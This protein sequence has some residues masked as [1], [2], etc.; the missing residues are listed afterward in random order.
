MEDKIKEKID[1]I[2]AERSAAFKARET[3]IQRENNF[4]GN[5]F[6]KIQDII[7]PAMHEL[8]EYLRS[9]NYYGNYDSD[10]SEIPSASFAVLPKGKRGDHP[11]N[12]LPRIMFSCDPPNE[13]VTIT[14]LGFRGKAKEGETKSISLE[15]LNKSVVQ[16]EI[17]A[18]ISEVFSDLDY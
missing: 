14:K 2:V 10:W 16:E 7:K 9:K 12:A 8:S 3:K 18:Y 15:T 13:K 17:A 11:I 5:F 4:R 1:S 6:G